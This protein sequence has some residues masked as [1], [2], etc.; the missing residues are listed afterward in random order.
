MQRSKLKNN[1]VLE[2]FRINREASRN[3]R[4]EVD[5]KQVIRRAKLNS[6]KKNQNI[7]INH[8][9]PNRNL[10]HFKENED[11]KVAE[12]TNKFQDFDNKI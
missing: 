10:R 5:M 1:T 12:A 2:Q 7:T 3:I 6:E 11:V 9:S 4:G 8:L